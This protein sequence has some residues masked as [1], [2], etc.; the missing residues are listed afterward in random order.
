MVHS[1][2]CACLLIAVGSADEQA[3]NT[4]EATHA[5]LQSRVKT[6]GVDDGD[7]GSCKGKEEDCMDRNSMSGVCLRSTKGNT[8]NF[9]MNYWSCSNSEKYCSTDLW[10][11]DMVRCCPGVCTNEELYRAQ[12]PVFDDGGIGGCQAS[13]EKCADCAGTS[14]QCL[15]S[16]KGWNAGHSCEDSKKW[17]TDHKWG[18]DM[19]ECCP[20]VCNT[21]PDANGACQ[22]KGCSESTGACTNC[23]DYSDMCLRQL[24][25]SKKYTCE[26]ARDKG[27]CNHKKFGPDMV[28]CCPGMCETEID[29]NAE[30]AVVR[31]RCGRVGCHKS[32][33]TCTNSEHNSDKC[34]AARRGSNETCVTARKKGM[35]TRNY[36]KKRM[37]GNGFKTCS[38]A[39]RKSAARPRAPMV[40]LAHTPVARPQTS[41]VAIAMI[42][43]TG[44]C[45]S[46]STATNGLARKPEMLAIVP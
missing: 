45:K 33:E 17:C 22:L 9:P 34:I 41:T 28:N 39:A 12:A 7:I 29:N 6:T 27:Y 38:S 4:G 23:T 40:R 32:E 3:V 30:D 24:W 31:G 21:S 8:W 1:P 44:A 15:R 36:K 37:A 19:L 13:K 2:F 10:S 18:Q 16:R 35:C 14:N 26:E 11:A 43:L 5:L 42:I 25:K 46:T 20:G